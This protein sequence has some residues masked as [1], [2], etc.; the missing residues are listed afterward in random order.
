MQWTEGNYGSSRLDLSMPINCGTGPLVETT[1]RKQRSRT[2]KVS[3][4]DPAEA[5]VRTE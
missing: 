3:P 2:E 1:T 4:G 5:I